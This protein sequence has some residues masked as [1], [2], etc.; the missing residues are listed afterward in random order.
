MTLQSAAAQPPIQCFLS[1]AHHD[2][3]VMKFVVPFKESLESFA[4]ADRGRRLEVFLDHQS[5][6]WG[7]DWQ[8]RL[9]EGVSG[10]LAFIPMITRRYFDRPACRE[11]L[12]AFYHG[13]E[14]LS[15]TDLLL[16]VIVLG[17][18]FV[19][20][21][22]PDQVVQIIAGR[23]HRDIQ[24]AVFAGPGSPEWNS[25]LL[26]LANDLVD[27]VEAVE[28][29][30]DPSEDSA[31]S[32]LALV[33]TLDQASSEVEIDDD[34]PDLIE[35]D[36]RL[37]ERAQEIGEAFVELVDVMTEIQAL[38]T[39]SGERMKG[40]TQKGP[41][42][43]EII[44]LA[45]DAKPLAERFEAI[46]SRMEHAATEADAAF[47]QAWE[48]TGGPGTEELRENLRAA[49]TQVENMA[50]VEE[51]ASQFLVQLRPMEVM[52]AGLRRSV[53]PLRRGTKLV[54]TT[55]LIVRSWASI[56]GGDSAA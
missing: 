13:A 19:R 38:F 20:T 41:N 26:G 30:F 5:I 4:E 27:A 48:L 31:R 44:R 18:S 14:A 47:R 3:Q 2:D 40:S 42:N 8:E 39:S 29:R 28:A 55:A 35:L 54:R 12:L 23:Q 45:R 9:R 10:A 21:D 24:P 33:T 7:E 6:G 46:G 34:A 56:A 43:P 25:T 17:R 11:E 36:E 52:S 37:G 32:G 16:P 22:S 1:Y 49:V 53:K 51:T 15:A 50:D